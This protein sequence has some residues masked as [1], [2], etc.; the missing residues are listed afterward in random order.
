MI[1]AACII[2]IA[3]LLQTVIYSFVTI[4][5]HDDWRIREVDI[6]KQKKWGKRL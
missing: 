2:A 4:V 5:L 1:A 3:I 6:G